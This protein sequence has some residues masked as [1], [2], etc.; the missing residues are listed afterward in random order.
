MGILIYFV[1]SALLYNLVEKK[2]SCFQLSEPD[3][4]I[5]NK[6]LIFYSFDI[7]LVFK[8][9][10]I[11]FLKQIHHYAMFIC[12]KKK[13]GHRIDIELSQEVPYIPAISV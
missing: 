13:D 11:K 6:N 7:Y 8:N 10:N 4:F 3:T 12:K 1:L 2:L 5:F 9:D